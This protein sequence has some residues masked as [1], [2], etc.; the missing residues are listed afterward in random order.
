MATELK[1]VL[2]VDDEI[3][4]LGSHIIFLE[5]KG[6]KVTK[7]TNGE[8]AVLLV[9][10]ESFDLVLLDE[11]MPGKDGLTTLEEI[12]ELKPH[13][14]VV[15][16]T[17]SEEESLMDDAIGQKIDDYLVKPVNPSQIIIV[18]KRLL[19]SKKIISGS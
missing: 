6:Y 18:I 11:M 17:K 13:L 2:W 8:D 9:G 12:K 7:A 3:D 19:D 15:M 4:K 5:Q 10:K 16:V 14:P 1:N